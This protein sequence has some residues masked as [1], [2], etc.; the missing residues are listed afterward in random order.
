M[1]SRVRL[2]GNHPHRGAAGT[3]R[4]DLPRAMGMWV[5]ELDDSHTERCYAGPEHLRPLP[6]DEDRSLPL[7]AKEGY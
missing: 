5:I 4:D 7:T 3:V 1:P 6:R 2:V